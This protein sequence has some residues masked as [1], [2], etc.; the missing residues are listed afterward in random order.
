MNPAIRLRKLSE[1]DLTFADALRAQAGWN[2]TLDDWRRFL[3]LDGEGCFLAE[4]NGTPAGTATTTTYGPTLAWI[5]MVLVQEDY[6]QRGI[7]RA[8]L[9][10]CISYLQNCGVRCIKLD[11]TPAG[12]P[13]YESLGFRTEWTLARWEGV[14]EPSHHFG[15]ATQPELWAPTDAER[16]ESLDLSAFGISRQRLLATLA[17]DTGT[18]RVV[19]LGGKLAGYGMMR[20]GTRAVYLGPIVAESP[21]IATELIEALFARAGTQRVYWDIPD[22]NTPA[23]GLAEKRGFIRQRS[24]TR[25]FW[26]ENLATGDPGK[27]FALAGP[28]LG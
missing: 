2:Q 12:K 7:G 17:R 4:W 24:L 25:M 22:P 16:A 27:Q 26:G 3:T 21:G 15:S 11:A 20:P 1:A 23:M 19:E 28:E 8:L 18:A 5:G 14:I 10:Q 9:Q 6:R 13:V